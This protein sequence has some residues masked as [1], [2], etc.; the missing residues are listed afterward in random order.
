[1]SRGSTFVAIARG[2]PAETE[3]IPNAFLE[4][5]RT[6]TTTHGTRGEFVKRTDTSCVPLLFSDRSLL[7]FESRESLTAASSL[8][9]IEVER[10][11]DRPRAPTYKTSCAPDFLCV[12]P[13]DASRP[14]LPVVEMTILLTLT[15]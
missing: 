11:D 3:G 14:S 9:G 10:N 6:I 7:L 1:M 13:R 12:S 15:V 2:I 5:A 8:N 4:G